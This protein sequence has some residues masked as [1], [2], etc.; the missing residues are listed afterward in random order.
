MAVRKQCG[1]LGWMQTLP[2]AEAGSCKHG[3]L[4]ASNAACQG[5]CKHG[6]QQRQAHAHMAAQVSNDGLM[7]WG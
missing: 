6:R 7:Q 3:R 5:D 1:M 2:P 4:Q